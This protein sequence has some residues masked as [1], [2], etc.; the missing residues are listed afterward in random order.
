MKKKLKKGIFKQ[1][2]LLVYII[3]LSTLQKFSEILRKLPPVQNKILHIRVISVTYDIFE[4]FDTSAF[5]S[6]MISINNTK[7]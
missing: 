1:A 7:Y 3:N 5:L 2:K 4:R 6:E